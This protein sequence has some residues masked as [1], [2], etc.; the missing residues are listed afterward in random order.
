MLV[1]MI[2]FAQ[3][4]SP[5]PQP[6]TIIDVF[7]DLNYWF[8]SSVTVA[9][10]TIFLTLLVSRAWK[11]ITAIW[12]QVVAIAIALVLVII[13]NVANIGFMADFNVL[14]TVVYGITIGFMANGVY[15]LKNIGK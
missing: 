7:A 14:S 15:D 11:N 9:G 8:S 4:T 13:G 10:L 3:D 6:G 12:K 2:T 1:C 5:Y